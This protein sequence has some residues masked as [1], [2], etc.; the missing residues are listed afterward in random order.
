MFL[1][2][3]RV[4]VETLDNVSIRD[5]AF[6]KAFRPPFFGVTGG[7]GAGGAIS[8]Y[9]RKG[10]DIKYVQ[11]EGLNFKLLAGYTSYK[12]FYNPDYSTDASTEADFR[13]TLYWEPFILTEKKDNVYHIEF[14]NNDISRKLLVIIEGI[15]AKG[16]LT[17][18]EKL[19]E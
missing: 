9:T 18:I 13:S 14:F 11:G 10:T 4:E 15:N 19:L 2:E 6:I 3:V 7:G 1:D 16:K 17:R 8:V 5:V 12:E